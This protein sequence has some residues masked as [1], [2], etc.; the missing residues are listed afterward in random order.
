[1]DMI[2]QALTNI[3][4]HLALWLAG[5]FVVSIALEY[6][7]PCNPDQPRWRRGMV[8]DLLYFFIMPLLTR[9]VR[10]LLMAIGIYAVLRGANPQEVQVFLHSGYGYL[11]TLPVWLQ[12]A[13][14]FIL[15]DIM[16]YWLHRWFHTAKMWRIH[17]IHHSSKH[18]DWLSTYRF[19]PVN[20]WISFTMVDVIMLFLGFSPMALAEMTAFN[21]AYSVMVH[22]NL[23]WTF[24]PFK[25]IFASPVFHRWHHT[26]EA[27]GMD[28]NF[29]PTFPLLDIMFG[30]FYMPDGKLPH[31]YGVNGSDIPN[32]FLRQLIWPF[33]KR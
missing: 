30:T 24:G 14:A 31:S 16:I 20:S 11:A 26:T 8:T 18:V 22:A 19:H 29:A 4:S 25:Y 28:K 15:S 6:A 9:I 2:L 10:L 23:N 33:T 21:T 32:G 5:T 7:M 13:L 27:E 17:A 12:A 3:Y 1:M